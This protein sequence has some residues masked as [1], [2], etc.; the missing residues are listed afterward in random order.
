MKRN[1][2]AI[3]LFVVLSISCDTSSITEEERIFEEEQAGKTAPKLTLSA[4]EEALFDL[5]NAHRQS[6]S[7]PQLIFGE[8]AYTYAEEHNAYMIAQGELSHT[9]FNVRAAMISQETNAIKVAENIAKDYNSPELA[10]QG[11]LG[12]ADHK[13]TIEGDYSHSALSIVNDSSGNPYYTQIFY[14][15][16]E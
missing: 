16:E 1:N 5:I 6:L 3:L 7:L 2:L 8:A 11:W 14:K 9:N 13:S 4:S 10:L 15:I 12:S